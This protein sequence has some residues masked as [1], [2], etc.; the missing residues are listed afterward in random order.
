MSALGMVRRWAVTFSEEQGK[1]SFHQQN[2]ILRVESSLR[3]PT[4][5]LQVR[6]D[7]EGCG[8]GPGKR[9]WVLEIRVRTIGSSNVASG[10]A[11]S[12]EV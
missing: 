4:F 8:N 3:V 5:H 9:S 10:L 2:L 7:E 1:M 11:V 12:A 6:P